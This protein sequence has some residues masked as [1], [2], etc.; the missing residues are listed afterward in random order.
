[1]SQIQPEPG[2][3]PDPASPDDLDAAFEAFCREHGITPKIAMIMA[4]TLWLKE[5][6][7]R[8]LA[9]LADRSAS[10]GGS[11]PASSGTCPQNS[12]PGHPCR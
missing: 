4:R 10:S 5:Q 9:A 11:A 1:M 2:A 6:T 7:T 8:V 12:A 3:C